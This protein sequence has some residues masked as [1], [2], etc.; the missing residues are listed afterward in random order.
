LL[1]RASV[2]GRAR[3]AIVFFTGAAALAALTGCGMSSAGDPLE[4]A[5]PAASVTPAPSAKPAPGPHVVLIMLENRELNEVIGDRSAPYLDALTRRGALALDY[6]AITHP[7]LPNY[8]ALIAGDPLG[9]SSDCTQCIAHGSELTDQL[10]SAHL[11]W[12]TYMQ[13]MPYPCYTGAEAGEYAK[14][15]DPFMYF[16]RIADSRA[17]CANVVPLSE[18][19]GA[20]STGTLPAFSWITPD[21]CDDGHNC[22]NSIVSRFLASIV[23]QLLPALGPQGLLAITWDEG[24]SDSGCC[25]LAAGG[26]VGLI[27]LGTQVRAGARLD[28]PADHYSLL[29]LIEQVFGLPRL[30]EAACAC[31]PSLDGAFRGGQPPRIGAGLPAA[32]VSAARR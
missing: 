25:K 15:H 8:I 2:R 24:S 26:R 31:T 5:R 27:L 19:G 11:G 29:A 17:R 1:A 14:K 12:R 32:G 21:L 4:S 9:I 3:L 30:R 13:A 7:S 10:E 22:A 6:H 20:L 16:G 23:P 18:L 28:A